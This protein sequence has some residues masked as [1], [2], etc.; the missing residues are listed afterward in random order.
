MG[1]ASPKNAYFW[2]MFVRKKKNRS[3]STSVVVVDKTKSKFKEVKVFG[4]SDDDVKIE[5]LYQEAKSWVYERQMGLNLFNVYQNEVEEHQV[6][7]HLLTNIDQVLLNGSQLLLNQVFKKVGFDAIED[8]IFKSL[9]IARLCEPLSKA[10]TVEYLKSH[11]DEDI[12][13]H[14]IYRYLDKLYNAQQEKIQ[15]IS[16]EHTR[17]ILGG[18]IG[19]MFYDVTT[20]YFEAENGDELRQSGFS[21]DG[22]HSQPQIVL[23]LLASKDGYPLSFSIFNGSQFESRTMIPIIDDFKQRFKV[24]DFV[25]VAD[26][27]LINKLNIKLL[28][29]ANYKYIIGARIKNESAEIT[30]WLLNLDK[31][32]G[33]FYETPKDNNRL[34]VGYS[35]KRAKKDKSNREKG[36]KRLTE[37]YK[38]GKITKDK[39]NKKGYN[40][41]LDISDNITVTINDDKIKED[42]KWD[43]LKGYITNTGLTAAEVY[44]QYSSLWEIERAYRITKGKIEM[45]PMFLFNPKRIQAHICICFA[46]YKIYKELE[47]VIKLKKINYSVEQVLN[48]AK[49]ITTIKVKLPTS[50]QKIIKTLFLTPKQKE[51]EPL[52]NE[53]FWNSI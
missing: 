41:F 30:N 4:T 50:G 35:E 49:T 23:G 33:H 20:L 13:L 19:L 44:S 2:A 29:S 15:Q 48:I 37:T 46:A 11:F 24:D 39:I 53:I 27:G 43:G 31:K 47:R 14:K 12:H 34:I 6:V 51:I 45:R 5:A 26:S 28:Q 25:I 38:T 10:G 17:K 18:H 21:K 52:F 3:G 42:K 7:S 36:I 16:V 40:K 1:D 22:K 9:T 8:S 32:D